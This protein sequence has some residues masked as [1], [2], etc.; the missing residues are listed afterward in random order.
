MKYEDVQ[1][2][3]RANVLPESYQKYLENEWFQ[4]YATF[5]EDDLESFSLKRQC[6]MDSVF[7]K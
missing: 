5:G 4:L 1:A 2:Q 3:K 6:S 7:S